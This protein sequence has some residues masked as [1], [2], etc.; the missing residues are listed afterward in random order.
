[1]PRTTGL[2]LKRL[3]SSSKDACGNGVVL[4]NWK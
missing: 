2:W 1:M 3:A 4:Q